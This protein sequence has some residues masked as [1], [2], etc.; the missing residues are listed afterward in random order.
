M[1][2][3]K[4][5]RVKV[6]TSNELDIEW[7]VIVNKWRV[8]DVSPPHWDVGDVIEDDEARANFL[9]EW[10]DTEELDDELP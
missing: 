8:T 3:I 1:S 2:V 6:I 5:A 10:E 9:F 7:D 4:T